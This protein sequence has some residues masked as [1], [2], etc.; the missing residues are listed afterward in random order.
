MKDRL[1]KLLLLEGF[2]VSQAKLIVAQ[3]AHETGNFTS[4]VFLTNRNPFGMKE[5][6]VRP[7]TAKGT[8]LNHAYYNSLED[9]VKDF[10]LWWQY[11]RMLA[12]YGGVEVYANVLKSKGYYEAG[13]A[14]YIR[15]MSY[16]YNKLWHES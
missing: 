12:Y 1:Y 16:F 14:E 3:A 4:P 9:A 5:P 7:T 2:D 15:G 6:K 11:N 8:R 13:I 10:R